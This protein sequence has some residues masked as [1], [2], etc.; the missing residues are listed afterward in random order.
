MTVMQPLHLASLDLN[1]LVAL[2]ALLEERNVTRAAERTGVTQS[3]MS[4]AL[5]RLRAL[6]GDPLLVRGK[7]GMVATARAEALAL[8][9]RRALEGIVHALQSPEPFEPKTA[10]L[11]IRIATSDYG[12]LVLLPKLVRRLER[13]APHIDLRLIPHTGDSL[14]PLVEGTVDLIVAPVR[15]GDEVQGVLAK[16]LFDESF[17]CIVRRGHPLAKKKL[18]LARFA[19]ASHALIAPRGREGS[20]ADDSRLATG[21]LSTRR[22][23]SSS[24]SRGSAHRRRVGPRAHPRGA[25]CLAARRPARPGGPGSAEGA[26]AHR[27]S[28]VGTVARADAAR[29]RPPLGARAVHR[30]READ[31]TCGP[32]HEVPRFLGTPTPADRRHLPESSPQ[33]GDLLRTR[34]PVDS[35]SPAPRVSIGAPAERCD[36]GIDRNGG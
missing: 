22:T 34:T 12:E 3:A 18:T 25:R 13:E 1:L 35:R 8:P 4:H 20:V 14:G 6:V 17:V 16:K 5:A 15:P 27:L 30:G 31:L 24:L 33:K 26:R 36:A 23:D 21:A 7:S 11:S 32:R 19:A 28:H 10:R 9:I 29:S 2:D